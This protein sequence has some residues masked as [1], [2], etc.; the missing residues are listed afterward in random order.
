MNRNPQMR[1]LMW[2]IVMCHRYSPCRVDA[3]KTSGGVFLSL[4]PEDENRY[5]PFQDNNC[6]RTEF[7][8]LSLPVF[9]AQWVTSRSRSTHSRTHMHSIDTQ[10]ELLRPV[11]YTHTRRHTEGAGWGECSNKVVRRSCRSR[12]QMV[13]RGSNSDYWAYTLANGGLET[14]RAKHLIQTKN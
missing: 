1:S 2:S 10:H 14:H 8:S 13:T 11:G 9:A 7:W 12:Q 5:Q 4:F 6:Y 3:L